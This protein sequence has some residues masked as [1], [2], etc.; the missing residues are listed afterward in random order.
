MTTLAR[1]TNATVITTRSIAGVQP[2]VTSP[3]ITKASK[4]TAK[5]NGIVKAEG[6]FP[7]VEDH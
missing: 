6:S 4:S 1:R 3:E 7:Q 2:M 5:R